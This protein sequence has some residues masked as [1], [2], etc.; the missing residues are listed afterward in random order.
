MKAM[1]SFSPLCSCPGREGGWPYQTQTSKL[2]K[3]RS[4]RD[5]NL[6]QAC[7]LGAQ[8]SDNA[9]SGQVSIKN[10]VTMTDTKY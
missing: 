4:K 9:D 3:N 10:N 5:L 1:S 6:W 2:A 8:D 7:E